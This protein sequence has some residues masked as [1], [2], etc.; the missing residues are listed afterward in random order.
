MDLKKE[1]ESVV[2]ELIHDKKT[3]DTSLLNKIQNEVEN[4]GEESKSFLHDNNPYNEFKKELLNAEAELFRGLYSIDSIR[5]DFDS[6]LRLD[7]IS[8]CIKD[9]HYWEEEIE[10]LKYN[11][12]KSDDDKIKLC[13]THLQNHW[14]KRLDIESS[15]WELDILKQI[16]ESFIEKMQEWLKLIEELTNTFHN[17]GL[18]PGYFLDFSE[19]K[20]SISD[21]DQ[22]RKWVDYIS[23]NKSLIELCDLLGRL[24]LAE[25][26]SRQEMIKEELISDTYTPVTN[27][28]E[29]IVGIRLGRDLEHALPQELAL[30][31]DDSTSTLFDLKYFEGRLMCFDM[32]GLEPKTE[33]KEVLVGVLEDEKMGPLIICVDTSG[34]MNGF[35]ETISKALTLYLSTRAQ[36][37]NRDCYLINFSTSI[38]TLD[39]SNGVSLPDLIKFLKK[40]FHGGTDVAPAIN[41]A[42]SLMEEENYKNAD[43]LIL[44]DFIMS[45]LPESTYERILK[46]KENDNKFYSLSIGNLFL[47]NRIRDVFDDEW[48]YNPSTCSIST[49]QKMVSAI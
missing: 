32:E 9:K 39:L 42:I 33:E 27:S 37:Q 22:I 10:G 24:R 49:I 15:R 11:Q 31:S 16:R 18:D 13:R 45:N 47:S 3:V 26:S 46:A 7:E 38:E 34:S 6:Y 44:S 29:E 40:S 25:K 30:L 19:G 2:D 12:E 17:L 43:L 36:A 23:N 14:K 28:N 8:K 35:P 48:V 21:I 5:D 1:E 20:I 41:H 4:W